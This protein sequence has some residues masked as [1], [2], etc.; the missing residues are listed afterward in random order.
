MVQLIYNAD[1][2]LTEYTQSSGPPREPG[3]PRQDSDTSSEDFTP[4]LRFASWGKNPFARKDRPRSASWKPFTFKLGFLVP[5]LLVTIALIVILELINRKGIRDGGIFFANSMA[6]FDK[7]EIFCYQYLPTILAVLYGMIWAVLDL[8]VK[9]LEPYF[10]LSKLEG[11]SGKD[12]IML[13]YPFEFLAYVP[14]ASFRRRYEGSKQLRSL[15]IVMLMR[16]NLQALDGIPFR[17]RISCN[18]LDYH[19]SP[20]CYFSDTNQN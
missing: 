20:E 7:W 12:S 15:Y 11:V 1:T 10:Q 14:I 2:N 8:D 9:R 4:A 17:L 16:Q 19:P 6:H 5:L 3:F 18:F 13:N